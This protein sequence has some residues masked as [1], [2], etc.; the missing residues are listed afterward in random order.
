M[1]FIACYLKFDFYDIFFFGK[2][3]YHIQY[4]NSNYTSATRETS[5]LSNYMYHGEGAK[6]LQQHGCVVA[7]DSSWPA[8]GGANLVL[9]KELS[10]TGTSAFDLQLESPLP[11]NNPDEFPNYPKEVV[12]AQ[13]KLMQRLN[14]AEKRIDSI[15][16]L[17][18]KPLRGQ[19]QRKQMKCVNTESPQ[20]SPFSLRSVPSPLADTA[21]KLKAQTSY[22]CRIRLLDTHLHCNQLS[23][24]KTKS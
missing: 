5:A 9:A 18:P 13:P 19:S 4:Y 10:N 21:N 20:F 6:I 17:V 2:S 22:A 16:K 3:L 14:A 15:I 12:Q 7:A 8:V 11:A 1:I 23:H 24:K